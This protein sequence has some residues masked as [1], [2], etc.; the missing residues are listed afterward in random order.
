MEVL[1]APRT[2]P[3]HI[4]ENNG[5]ATP[6]KNLFSPSEQNLLMKRND[7][8]GIF[9]L[10]GLVLIIYFPLLYSDYLYTDESGELWYGRKHMNFETFITQGR[11]VSYLLFSGLFRHVHTIHEVM[12]IR[13]FSLFGWIACLPLWYYI[14]RR[15]VMDNG[16]PKMLAPLSLVYLVCMPP[17]AI[18]I[19]WAAC[20][21]LF[22]ACTAGLVSGYALYTAIMHKDN[23]SAVTVSALVI[24][25]LF[26][27]LSL[28][29][30]QS[31]FGCFFIPFLI[32]LLATKKFAGT[33]LIG[34]GAGLF[35]Y[36]V[37]FL[38]F[39]LTTGAGASSRSALA[40]DPLEKL[41][42]FLTRPMASAFHFTFLFNE[43]NFQGLISYAVLALAWLIATLFRQRA[44]PL[45]QKFSY[46][47]GLFIFFLLLYLPSLVVKEDYASNRT[48]LALDL[49]V[50]FLVTETLFSIFSKTG[51]RNALA[52]IL[53]A[54]F[55]FNAGFNF[56]KEFLDPLAAEY[57]TIKDFV[58]LHLEPGITRIFFIR[59]GENTFQGKYGIVTSWDE[60]GVPST[61]KSWTPEPLI[62]QL[63]FEKT[64]SMAR[65]EKIIV[66]SWPDEKAFGDYGDTLS[67]AT[68]FINADFLLEAP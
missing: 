48:L 12:Y 6:E 8:I 7:L 21:E 23:K 41:I 47:A 14:I 1:T 63:V 35:I 51:I 64:G 62:R 60:F 57:R 50:F 10:I 54:L 2:Q 31:G 49:A 44:L 16:L 32:H 61:A 24:S 18:S 5:H 9:F 45:W 29:T 33:S 55:L 34:I 42:Y 67:K 20:L 17:F 66:R 59:P 4:L 46:L 25:L 68:L 39:R 11:Y 27:L 36:L 52:E 26:G 13:L 65:A 58:S 19:G 37:Y 15:L 3:L 56:R 28:F 22:I 40:T 38:L 43:R 30:Y 53:A